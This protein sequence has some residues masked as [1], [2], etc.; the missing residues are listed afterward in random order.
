MEKFVGST[1]FDILA[2]RIQTQFA[3][4]VFG[5]WEIVIWGRK[6]EFDFGVE[7]W[8]WRSSRKRSVQKDLACTKQ[9]LWEFLKSEPFLTLSDASMED[10]GNWNTRNSG[11]K[12]KFRSGR[13]E[14]PPPL[15]QTFHEGVAPPPCQTPKRCATP[16]HPKEPL[17]NLLA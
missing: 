16:P 5:L 11:I 17:E 2:T 12:C 9:S 3:N 4:G 10:L 7:N 14:T 1:T 13:A 6:T 15:T 8:F